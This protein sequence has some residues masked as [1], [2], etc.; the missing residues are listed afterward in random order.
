MSQAW[1]E[2]SADK[3][4][5]I[6]SFKKCGIALAIDDSEDEEINIQGID[7]YNVEDDDDE[8]FTDEEDPFTDS[9]SSEM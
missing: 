8:E 4:M 3:E 1:E 5:I 7:G 9:D 6:G 2:V